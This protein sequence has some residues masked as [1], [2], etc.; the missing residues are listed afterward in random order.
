MLAEDQRSPVGEGRDECQSIL[1]F[2]KEEVNI[3]PLQQGLRH[4]Q[5]ALTNFV[6]GRTKYPFLLEI[7]Q[8]WQC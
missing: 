6:S 4:L 3:I 5:T 7:A 2:Y 8:R 1:Q